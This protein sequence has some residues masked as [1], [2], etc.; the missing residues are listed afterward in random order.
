MSQMQEGSLKLRRVQEAS[1]Q[2]SHAGDV[3]EKKPS[4]AFVTVHEGCN[5]PTAE[6]VEG[7]RHVA[8]RSWTRKEGRIP[9]NTTPQGVVVVKNA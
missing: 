9:S 4:T 2:V 1:H 3:F 6:G 8:L 5:Y 7:G